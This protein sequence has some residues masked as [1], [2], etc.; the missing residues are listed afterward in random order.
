M[1]HG[2]MKSKFFI[3]LPLAL[4]GVL[5]GGCASSHPTDATAVSEPNL[6]IN[7]IHM[8][9]ADTGWAQAYGTNDFRVLQTTDGGQTWKD[10]TPRPFPY[11]PYG[12]EFPKLSTAWISI[13]TNS[14]AGLLITTN[15]GASWAKTTAP[16]GFFTEASNV[17]FYNANFGVAQTC[18]GGLG[19]SYCTFYETHDGGVTW[20]PFDVIPRSPYPESPGTFI[21]SNI[22]GDRLDYYP[23]GKFILVYGET[24]DEKPIGGIRL[25]ISANAGKSWRGL[26]LP[27]PADYRGEYAVPLSPIFFGA[28]YG[29]L[30][31][32]VF[33]RDDNFRTFSALIF[34]R[35]SDGGNTW[36]MKRPVAGPKRGL[37]YDDCDV[38]SLNDIIVRTGA[39][40]EVTHDGARSWRTMK[41]N[42]D[43]GVEGSKR[44]VARL[45][46]VDAKH[47]WLIISDNS[48]F[49]PYGN[50]R[51][52]KTSDG[53]KTWADLPLKILR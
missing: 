32:Q 11:Q 26:Q 24:G 2:L 8:L 13:R 19:S 38:I 1:T 30:P 15:G 36:T 35:T 43:L 34:Y 29:L 52:Y 44:D 4:I 37:G 5:L 42:I 50:V 25:S 45:D 49:S 18:D 3:C 46:F 27:L 39:D 28:R 17:H 40:F 12:C 23:P 33:T 6:H 14:W 53:G 47:G 31:V 41:P 7:S 22:R 9:D 21:L 20:K 48:K 51:L 16:F 10:V